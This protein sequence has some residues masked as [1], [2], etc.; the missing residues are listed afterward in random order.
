[1]DPNTEGGSMGL[2][3]VLGLIQGLGLWQKNLSSCPI[4]YQATNYPQYNGFIHVSYRVLWVL[5]HNAK[6]KHD[7]VLRFESTKTTEFKPVQTT[8][9]KLKISELDLQTCTITHCVTDNN[10]AW[11]I[12]NGN[13]KKFFKLEQSGHRTYEQLEEGFLQKFSITYENLIC[14]ARIP[15]TLSE[16]NL[17]TGDDYHND[18]DEVTQFFESFP[19]DLI[20]LRN[21]TLKNANN[22]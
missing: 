2:K 15:T 3:S 12:E 4:G 17:P 13:Y 22:V 6:T 1:M 9:T 21:R 5:F 10:I 7:F 18:F 8:K 20:L 14:L 19:S 16:G 11:Q